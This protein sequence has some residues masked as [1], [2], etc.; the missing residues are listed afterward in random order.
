MQYHA[1]LTSNVLL[2][3][4]AAAVSAY[5]CCVQ[6]ICA[7]LGRPAEEDLDFVTS[8]KAKRYILG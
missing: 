5:C 4:T 1:V 6:I 3:T 2:Y 7:K 8:M